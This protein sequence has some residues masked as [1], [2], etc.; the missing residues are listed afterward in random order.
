MLLYLD[1]FVVVYILFFFVHCVFQ[2]CFGAAVISQPC[3][4]CFGLI[5]TCLNTLIFSLP[6]ASDDVSLTWWSSSLALVFLKR[7]LVFCLP[8]SFVLLPYFSSS[9]PGSAPRSTCPPAPPAP[10]SPPPPPPINSPIG[11]QCLPIPS[12]TLQAHRALSSRHL[13]LKFKPKHSPQLHL[14]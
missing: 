1:L 13:Q 8:G 10:P 3:S 9:E 7:L 12:V 6:T 5:S 4:I 14:T 11:S 2:I